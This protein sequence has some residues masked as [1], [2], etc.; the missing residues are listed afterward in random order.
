MPKRK[1]KPARSTQVTD[2]HARI[3]ELEETLRAI[4]MGEVDAVL[5]SGP[6]GDQVFTLQGAEHP[7]RLMVETIDEGAATLADDGTVLYANR[8]FA[9]IFDIPLEKFIGAPLNDFVFGEDRELLAS[10]IAD[11]N[12]NIVRGEI[13][14][15]SHRQRPRTIRLTLSPVREQGGHTICVVA[16]ELTELIETNEALRVSELSLRQL[17]A[18]LLKLQ[19]E[20]RRR[21]ARDLHDTTGQ[22]I[23]VLSMTLDRLAK[24]VDT[25]KVDVKD[26]L[27]ESREVVG[28]IG[29]EIRT[30][31]YLL[32]PPLLDEC[33]LASAVLWY[34]EGFKKRSGIHLSVSIDEE[35]VRLTT[36]AETALFRVLQESLTNVHRY[37]GSP[38]AEIRIFQSPSKVHLEIVDHGKGVKGGTERSTFAGAPTLG[39]GIPGMRERIRQLGGQLEVEFSNEGARVYATLPRVAST[40]ESGERS[41]GEL[42]RDKGNFQANLRQRPDVRKRILIAD[43]HEVMRRGVR[44]LV[45]SQEEWSVCGE[46]IEGNEAVS[47]TKELRPDLLILDV[48]MPGMSGIEA[49]VHILKDD[50]NTKI[51]FFTMHDSPQMM[52]EISNVGAWGY[53]AKARAGNDL[54]DA[55]RII[56]D[57]KKFFPRLASAR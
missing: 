19:D 9:E 11:A 23:A 35:L 48:S 18:R 56:L 51:L 55:V 14:L 53:V 36:D 13:R 40:E 31:S 10:L 28:K 8:S 21:I 25:G 5:V 37:S 24:L 20:E 17:S 1:K 2:L 46:A 26:A 45:E 41:V 42:F 3:A 39:V 54:V 57:G 7:Y 49:A 52:R 27:T 43:D 15:D 6:H 38:S 30:L 44:G 12:I 32:H 47:K 29:E 33:G 22:K 34:A 50:P 16:T 4:R